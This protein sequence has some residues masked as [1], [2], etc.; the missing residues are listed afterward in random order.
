ML[1]A[2]PAAASS[3]RQGGRHAVP[4]QHLLPNQR[5]VWCSP[6]LLLPQPS[7]VQ[8]QPLSRLYP[9][10][11]RPDGCTQDL[12]TSWRDS[13]LALPPGPTGARPSPPA[14]AP[15]A[16]PTLARIPP[17]ATGAAAPAGEGLTPSVLAGRTPTPE[18]PT[19]APATELPTPASTSLTRPAT[20]IIPYSQTPLPERTPSRFGPAPVAAPPAAERSTLP[21]ILPAPAAGPGA[22]AAPAPAAE[23]APIVIPVYVPPKSKDPTVA[24][25]QDIIGA[26]GMC[27]VQGACAG[28]LTLQQP[29]PSS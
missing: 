29:P 7:A 10:L 1:Q 18:L 20:Y 6:R 25:G 22:V 26:C 2:E 21:Q 19:R 4:P 8:R 15:R 14:Q 5:Q 28:R 23:A 17:S 11:V 3:S 27:R 9:R 16:E 24:T 13:P 12:N